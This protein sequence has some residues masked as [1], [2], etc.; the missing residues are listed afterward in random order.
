[1]KVGDRPQ[2]IAVF[3]RDVINKHVNSDEYKTAVI[4]D[5]YDSGKN[6]TI[7]QYQK[8]LTMVNGQAIPDRYSATHRMPTNFF[9]VYTTQLTQYLLGNGVTWKKDHSAELGDDFDMQVWKIAK[10]AFCGG[11]A[12]GFYHENRVIV[13]TRRN[14]A[15]VYDEMTGELCMGVNFWQL[16]ASRPLYATL[17][18]RDGLTNFLW[19]KDDPGDEWQ[20]IDDQ[21]YMQPKT[22]YT[23]VTVGDAKDRA[24]GTVTIEEGEPV[25]GFPIIPL[26]ANEYHQSELVGLRSKID[27]YDFILNGFED[28]L[29]NAQLYWVISGAGGMDDSDLQQ[30]LDRLRTVKAVATQEPDQEVKPVTVEIPY[31]ARETLLDRLNKQLYRDAMIMN[32]EDIAGGATTATQIRAAYERQNVKTDQFEYCVLEFLYKL[33][34][35]AGIEDQPTFTRSVIINVQEEIQSLTQVAQY[36][37]EEYVRKKAL[38]LFGDGDKFDDMQKQIDADDMPKLNGSGDGGGDANGE[39]EET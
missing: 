16:E 25:N 9:N 13:F 32:P 26:Y 15:A 29:D 35:I 37:T 10:K 12:Y 7:T 14:F 34:E 31:A 5:D 38:T 11:A 8:M 33:M 24:D 19:A 1:M 30:L 23:W 18:E 6:T 20:K 2:D 3:V 36:F 22:P 21:A 28:D 4:A 17:Y 39:D 27:A